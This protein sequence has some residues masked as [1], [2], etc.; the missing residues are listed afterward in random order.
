MRNNGPVTQQEV[1][2][3][4][5]DM[6]VSRTDD[7]GR[8]TFVNQTFVAT[9]G[10]S[11]AELLGAPHNLVRHPDMPKAA[12]ADLWATV[13]AGQPWEGVVKNRAKSGA[14][15]WVRANVTP[16]QEGGRITGYVSIR[17]K[18]SRADVAAAERLYATL[19]QGGRGLRLLGGQVLRRGPVHAALRWLGTLDARLAGLALMPIAGLGIVAAGAPIMAAVAFA[20]PGALVQAWLLAR[21]IRGILQR[22]RQDIDALIQGDHLRVIDLPP[23]RDFQ[24]AAARLRA[25]RAILAY[26]ARER[27]E[28]ET[29]SRE[30]SRRALLETCQLIESDLEA[31]WRDINRTSAEVVSAVTGLLGNIQEVRQD[32]VVV[33]TAA[34]QASGTATTVA[35]AAE[36]QG[37]AGTEIASQAARS[38]DIARRAVEDARNAARALQRM[39]TAAAEVG[40]VLALIH[41][42]ASQTTLLALNATI[43]AARAGEAGKGFSVVAGEVKSLSAQTARATDQIARQVTDIAGAMDGSVQALDAVIRT[44]ELIDQAATATAAAVEEQAAANA[45]IGRGAAQSADVAN[46]VSGSVDHIRGQAETV[47]LAAGTVSRQVAATNQAVGEMKTR[48]LM[49]LRQSVAGDRRA[50]DRIPCDLPATLTLDGRRLAARVTDLSLGGAVAL[51]DGEERAAASDGTAVTLHLDGVGD[52]ACDLAGRSP[53]GLHVRFLDLDGAIRGRLA[54]VYHAMIAADE[55]LITAAQEVAAGMARALAQ[56][57]R[58]GR[59]DQD[60]LFDQGLEP[61]PGTVPEQFTAPYAA[62]ADAVFPP[63]QDP[64][65]DLDRRIVFCVATATNGYVPTHNTGPGAY[66]GAR[67]RRRYMDRTALAAARN[68]RPFLIQA[69]HRDEGDGRI[70][71]MKEIDCPIVVDRRLWGNVRLGF[72]F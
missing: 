3:R 2:I 9:S 17:T 72:E 1:P 58:D 60:A 32:T 38:S 67:G 57:L 4:D 16:V 61:I 12:F 50:F 26:Q 69:Y 33:A 8:I 43:E 22:Q 7:K 40:Q 66:D 20:V 44:I 47:C 70:R 23:L 19:R 63:L 65:L 42:I 31:T 62:L 14:H 21:R 37:A 36:Q 24:P 28:L 56:A 54:A 6:L 34:A 53:A 35:A 52:L 59:I 45:E 15:Y 64:V 18:P 39:E 10:F 25:L 11:E 68:S 48:L 49:V 5:G 46:Q 71:R 55:V 13:Q 30:A 27:A 51:P 29:R 41:D